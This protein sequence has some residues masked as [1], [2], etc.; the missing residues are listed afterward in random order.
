MFQ[1]TPGPR[2][3]FAWRWWLWA[4]FVV[5]WTTG[6]VM[7]IPGDDPWQIETLRI[8]LKFLLGK[9]L[10]ILAYAVLTVL[11]GWLGVGPRYRWLLMFLLMFHA[12]F[13]EFVQYHISY[14]SGSLMDVLFDSGGIAL[15]AVI[16][17]TWWTAPEYVA[18]RP[19]QH[20]LAGAETQDRQGSLAAARSRQ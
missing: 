6:L 15:G 19:G 3:L 12:G 5:L 13:T 11:T 1:S 18:D 4:A 10:H 7:P 20:A 16:S 14:R 8:S 9:S 2:R 17:W